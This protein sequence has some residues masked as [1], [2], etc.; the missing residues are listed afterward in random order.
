M[1]SL[2]I[3]RNWGRLKY[4]CQKEEVASV[5]GKVC[6]DLSDNDAD[7]EADPN[8]TK[9]YEVVAAHLFDLVVFNTRLQVSTMIYI[10]V[11]T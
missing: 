11:N 7:P 10:L 6:F 8:K 4:F 5:L 3:Y 1:A 2:T 9:M